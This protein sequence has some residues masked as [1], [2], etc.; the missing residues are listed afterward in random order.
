MPKR[1]KFNTAGESKKPIG[2][3]TITYPK[4]NPLENDLPFPGTR[5]CVLWGFAQVSPKGMVYNWPEIRR[6]WNMWPTFSLK[7]FCWHFHIPFWTAYEAGGLRTV[8][9]QAAIIDGGISTAR[10]INYLYATETN[11]KIGNEAFVTLVKRLTQSAQVMSQWTAAISERVHDGQAIPNTELTTTEGANIARTLK[12]LT[13]CA[14]DLGHLMRITGA[15][16][17]RE[18]VKAI[19][20]VPSRATQQHDPPPIKQANKTLNRAEVSMRNTKAQLDAANIKL[21]PSSPPRPVFKPIP[22]PQ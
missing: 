2:I 22:D 4:H 17:R 15:D 6:Q 8:A 18:E 1:R 21:A 9:K 5:R 20:E 13:E 19:P 16:K 12:S 7:D 3:E 10:K 14:V 11:P